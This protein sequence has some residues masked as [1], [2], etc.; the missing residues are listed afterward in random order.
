MT[1]PVAFITGAASGIGLS[2]A[3]ELAARGVEVTL[4][5]RD[6]AGLERA[7]ASLAGRRFHLATLDVR[8]RGEV[9]R[10]IQACFGRRGRLDLVFNNAGV[11]LAAETRDMSPKDWERILEINVSGVIHG[12]DAAYPLMLEQG[13]GHI[14]NVASLAGL[15][16]LPGETAYVTSKYA[17]VGLSHALRAEAADLGVR[18]SVACP[19]VIDTPIYDTSPVLGF[20]KEQA[21]ALWPQGRSPAHCARAILRGVRRNQATIVVTP[22]AQVLWR[23]HRLSPHLYMH[24]ARLYMRRMRQTRI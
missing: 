6:A 12:V 14:V 1:R 17:V 18:V 4:A 7:Q 2:L 24:A 11:G 9:T 21:L 5:D 13:H 10:A 16:P 8:D 3:Q 23:L 22:A 20:D 15:I 19:G